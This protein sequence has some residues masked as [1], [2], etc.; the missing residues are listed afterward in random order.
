MTALVYLAII[1]L[2]AVFLIPWLGRHRD[3]Q[4]GRRSGERYNRAMRTLASNRREREA[5]PLDDESADLEL[6]D[7]GVSDFDEEWSPAGA[8]PL[9]A[10]GSFLAGMRPSA[11][12]GEQRPSAAK[13]ARRRRTVLVGVAGIFLASVIAAAA[14]LL[15]GAAPAVALALLV[16]YLTALA[17]QARSRRGASS[18]T[19]SEPDRYREAARRAQQEARS[20]INGEVSSDV[21]REDG[22]D[23]RPTTLPTYVSKPKA[24]KVPRILR[25]DGASQE[26]TGQAMVQRAQEEQR[27]AREAQAQFER[28][29]AFVEPDP[30]VEMERLANPGDPSPARQAYRRAANG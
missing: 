24:S 14:G 30:V 21:R 13:A 20:V 28:E 6:S 15:P 7:F 29:M 27:R 11:R 22:W 12:H 5:A 3:E 26:W 8:P 9:Q 18:V 4:N 16:A 2:W 23:A 25:V 19:R 17:G 1:A 10:L